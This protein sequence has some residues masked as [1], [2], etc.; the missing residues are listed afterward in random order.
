MTNLFA[1]GCSHT[2]GYA[3]PDVV[4]YMEEHQGE[5]YPNKFGKNYNF[6]SKYS[7]TQILAKKLNM[8]C[9]NYGC[10]GANSKEVVWYF[11]QC[12][13]HNM[14]SKGDTVVILWPG[15]QRTGIFYNRQHDDL[16]SSPSRR[17]WH[18]ST[19]DKKANVFFYQYYDEY[20]FALQRWREIILVDLLCK[21]R[22]INCYHNLTG[23]E[24]SPKD[25]ELDL[26]TKNMNI[27]FVP[28]DYK[29]GFSPPWIVD[30]A[31]DGA[32]FGVESQKLIA[33]KWYKFISS[34]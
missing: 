25:V 3:L 33:D 6:G 11:T 7:W 28:L 27:D 2:F 31:H 29:P 21:E 23:E 14:I 4:Q 10:C 19:T 22:G 13:N 1:F 8:E 12:L 24:L 5:I 16:T 18:S 30:T 17:M 34:T 26:I 32:H 9:Y 20:D 15:F